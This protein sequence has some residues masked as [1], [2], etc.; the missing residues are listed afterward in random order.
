MSKTKTNEVVTP[1]FI[2]NFP[3]LFD[4]GT[5]GP[6]EGKYSIMMMF[7]MQTDISAIKNVV[8][9]AAKE[10]W[11][12]NIPAD[13]RTP[14]K[15]GNTTN[16]EEAKDKILI[17]SWSKHKPGV[18]DSEGNEIEA[19]D[20]DNIYSGSIGKAII[21]AYAYD[22]NI[23]KSIFQPGVVLML[24]HYMFVKDGKKLSTGG[25]SSARAAFGF[26]EKKETQTNND[27]LFS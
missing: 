9:E 27:D 3:R 19:F 2:V 15:N 22:K 12:G 21:R 6:D 10:K 8:Q 4:K 5:K 14:W 25:K 7:S 26:E 18:I 20:K 16:L 24:E 13:L 11:G 17:R 23:E 1:E